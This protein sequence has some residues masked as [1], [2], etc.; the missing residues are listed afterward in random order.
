[1]SRRGRMRL[2]CFDFLVEYSIGFLCLG[3]NVTGGL[4]HVVG[5]VI[6]VGLFV[7]RERFV[8]AVEFMVH[9]VDLRCWRSSVR[10]DDELGFFGHRAAVAIIF[11]LIR[12][13]VF[14]CSGFFFLFSVNEIWHSSGVNF[15]F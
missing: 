7:F 14:S 2:C 15:W 13:I 4:V 10:R 6:G 3:F 12:I 1:M 8:V 9:F 11:I 5:V